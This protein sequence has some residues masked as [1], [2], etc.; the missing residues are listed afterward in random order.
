MTIDSIKDFFE[1][2]QY[3]VLVT[4]FVALWFVRFKMINVILVAILSVS[5]V[6][7]VMASVLACL[8]KDLGLLYSIS[9]TVHHSLWLFLICKIA[10]RIQLFYI[11]FTLFF[12]FAMVNLFFI[13]RADA[14]YITF[15]TGAFLYTMIYIYESF[16]R[17]KNEDFAFFI[18]NSFILI[19]APVLF[20]LGFSLVMGFQNPELSK[21]PVL[22]FKLY[23]AIATIV[24]VLYYTLIN[25]YVY[26]E[27]RIKV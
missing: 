11:A 22:G 19:S 7:E 25:M 27:K 24:N 1:P 12:L 20:F 3:Y 14:F 4:F 23:D 21:T 6:T 18:S 10:G 13:G 8:D 16:Y 2:M 26:F 15:I 9:V 17:L 5:F